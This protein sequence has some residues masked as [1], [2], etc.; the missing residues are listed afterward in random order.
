MKR[1][2]FPDGSPYSK[3]NAQS[4]GE[5]LELHFP[6]SDFKPKEIVDLARP[7]NSPIHKFFDWNDSTAAE[8]YRRKQ[9]GKL[10]AHLY[11]K[12][13]DSDV[14]AYESVRFSAN[15]SYMA[16][17]QIFNDEE[18]WKQVVETA[19]R[20]LLYWEA[21]YTLYRKHLPKI[22]SAIDELKKEQADEQSKGRT[23]GAKRRAEQR[24]RKAWKGGTC[25]PAFFY[26]TPMT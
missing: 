7:K 10:V 22:F 26:A 9:A 23:A 18:L 3:H 12:I 2:F 13:E 4:V 25:N 19:K 8:K 21:K 14:K 6:D 1:Y 16:T 17:D 5:F 15:K 20:E 24:N 11:V